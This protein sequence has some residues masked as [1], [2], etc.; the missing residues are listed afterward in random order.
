MKIKFTILAL[1][2]WSFSN[3]KDIHCKQKHAK[4]ERE[5]LPGWP[6]IATFPSGWPFVYNLDVQVYAFIQNLPLQLQLGSHNSW[7]KKI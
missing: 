5:F 2:T 7:T 1:M 3:C 6:F 4:K